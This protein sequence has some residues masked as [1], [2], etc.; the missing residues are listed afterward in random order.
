M[1]RVTAVGTTLFEPKATPSHNIGDTYEDQYGR[2]FVYARAG[3]VALV[4]GNVIQAPAQ[5]TEHDQLTPTAAVAI[6]AYTVTVTLGSSAVTANQYAGG[7]LAIDTTPGLGEDYSSDSHPAADS[8][9]TCVFT[10]RYPIRVALT[11][12]SRVTLSPNPFTLV[13]Q[14]PVTTR[15]GTCAGVAPT[16]VS[17]NYYVWLGR[18]GRFSTLIQGTPTVG[19]GLVPQASAAGA[20]AINS[21]TMP[22]VAIAAVTGVDGKCLPVDWVLP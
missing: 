22:S 5:N 16:A 14:A 21:S 9:A 7:T 17:I 12:S 1:A 6:G 18:R 2:L 19:H 15:T 8:A 3:G 13:I 20:L 11:T 10:L 4:A